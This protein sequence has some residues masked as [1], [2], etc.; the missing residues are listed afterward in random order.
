MPAG[1]PLKRRGG[2][3]RTST[4]STT[5]PPAWPGASRSAATPTRITPG[6]RTRCKRL[7]E[8]CPR[9]AA[10]LKCRAGSSTRSRGRP[11]RQLGWHG[12]R[13]GASRAVVL[14]TPASGRDR[15]AARILRDDAIQQ[16]RGLSPLFGRRGGRRWPWSASP[17]RPR[18]AVRPS[19][20]LPPEGVRCGVP[21]CRSKRSQAGGAPPSATRRDQQPRP[22]SGTRRRRAGAPRPSHLHHVCPSGFGVGARLEGGKRDAGAVGRRCPRRAVRHERRVGPGCLPCPAAAP[23]PSRRVGR[24]A[25][26]RASSRATEAPVGRGHAARGSF[27]REAPLR[28]ATATGTTPSR[29]GGPASG[30]RAPRCVFGTAALAGGA[31]AASGPSAA[32]GA[33]PGHAGARVGVAGRS[34]Q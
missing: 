5:R 34:G 12:P 11:A 26:L 3:S 24:G 32:A 16:A 2:S 21:G 10:A 8:P 7:A 31:E 19:P 17:V 15:A 9:R 22:A 29:R 13:R 27:R 23:A 20:V 30:S 14:R 33:A 25:L 1:G 6:R 18:R 28:G 4:S